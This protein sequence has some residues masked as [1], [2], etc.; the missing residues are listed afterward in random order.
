[1]IIL[2]MLFTLVGIVVLTDVMAQEAEELTGVQLMQ[3][4]HKNLHSETSVYEEL[5]VIMTD[6]FGNRDT[7][8]LRKY[9]KFNDD[10]ASKFLLIFDSP[11]EFHGVALLVNMQSHTSPEIFLYLPAYGQMI[12]HTTLWDHRESLFGTDFSIRDLTGELLENYQFIRRADRKIENISFFVIDVFAEMVDTAMAMPLMQHFIHQ[13]SLTIART[14]YF[15]RNG[16]ISKQ[17][18]MHNLDESSNNIW[19]AGMLLME[20]R[21]KNHNTLIK[22]NT[23]IVSEDYVPEEVFTYNWLY[24][25]HPPLKSESSEDEELETELIDASTTDQEQSLVITN[26]GLQ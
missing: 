22:I 10:E 24:E 18:T 12:R 9:A 23:R 16:K 7:R 25:N 17:L 14:D 21:Q 15:G 11:E 4:V 8:Q 5:S 26:S 1:M 3:A 19:H 20:D 6:E 13:D 2:R